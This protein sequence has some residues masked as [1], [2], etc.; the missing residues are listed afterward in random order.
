MILIDTKGLELL[1]RGDQIG[2]GVFF[3][4]LGLLK[5]AE[6]DGAM[7]IKIFGAN[8][9]LVGKLFVVDGLQ[10]GIEGVRRVS[11]LHL[12]GATDLS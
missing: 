12:A 6:R 5:L 8:V 7:I 10:V 9:C 2:F 11:A 4:V 3:G 1:F